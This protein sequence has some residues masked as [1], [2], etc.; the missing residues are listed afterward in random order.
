MAE[1]QSDDVVKNL[2]HDSSSHGQ[3]PAYGA[4]VGRMGRI[5]V[6]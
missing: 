5:A 2:S 1:S 6:Q 3:A 4:M